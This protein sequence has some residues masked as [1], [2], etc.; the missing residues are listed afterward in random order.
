MC[1]YTIGRY[2]RNKGDNY[3]GE[4]IHAVHHYSF[5]LRGALRNSTQPRLHDM[6]AVHKLLLRTRLQ[7]NLVLQYTQPLT[8]VE[9]QKTEITSMYIIQKHIIWLWLRTTIMISAFTFAYG[10]KKSKAV[11]CR[12]NFPDFVIFPKQVPILRRFF[13][14]TFPAFFIRSSLQWKS[15]SKWLALKERD[16]LKD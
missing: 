10:A 16:T 12:W 1:I 7:P 8:G 2:A 4:I 11:I 9:Y 5:I 14:E 3:Q 6:M 15:M 13:L